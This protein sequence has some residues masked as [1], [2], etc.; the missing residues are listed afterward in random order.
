MLFLWLLVSCSCLMVVAI[1]QAGYRKVLAFEAR[2]TSAKASC[3]PYLTTLRLMASYC[4]RPAPSG[5]LLCSIDC[6]LLLTLRFNCTRRYTRWGVQPCRL[7][8][9]YSA[10]ITSLCTASVPVTVGSM[11]S[12]AS[13][14]VLLAASASKTAC[15]RVFEPVEWE[16]VMSLRCPDDVPAQVAPTV[17]ACQSAAD[18]VVAV[19]FSDGSIAT[20]KLSSSTPVSLVRTACFFCAFLCMMLQFLLAFVRRRANIR[21]KSQGWL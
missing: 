12:D 1:L 16:Q 20:Y 3:A 17:V 6:A 18:P 15:V 10:P 7:M 2:S 8:A 19:G 9:G 5:E 11:A 21:W 4:P 14:S 13:T